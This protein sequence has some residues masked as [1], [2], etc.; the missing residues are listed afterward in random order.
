MFLTMNRND[1]NVR[2]TSYLWLN[3]M[4]VG[5][6][7]TYLLKRV[8]SYVLIGNT[9]EW[10]WIFQNFFLKVGFSSNPSFKPSTMNNAVIPI[11]LVISTT[12][13]WMA[14]GF[15]GPHHLG[16]ARQIVLPPVMQLGTKGDKQSDDKIP[17]SS[18]PP[19]KAQDSKKGGMPTFWDLFK[20]DGIDS[21][22]DKRFAL[23]SRPKNVRIELEESRRHSRQDQD[24]QEFPR[25]LDGHYQV[26]PG[27]EE[28]HERIRHLGE[29]N[30]FANHDYVCQQKCSWLCQ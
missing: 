7:S 2:N 22:L 9:C 25:L 6:L 27:Q 12:T 14:D 24:F 18:A 20:D 4:I 23:A 15:R 16:Q 1:H 3:H 8:C 21:V 30:K 19:I 26:I 28:D 11:I 17:S 5:S 10:G 13:T 29:I